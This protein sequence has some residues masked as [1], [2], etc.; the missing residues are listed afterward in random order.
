MKSSYYLAIFRFTT[1]SILSAKFNSI[2]TSEFLSCLKSLIKLQ[3]FVVLF[4]NLRFHNEIIQFY[5]YLSEKW[6]IGYQKALKFQNLN[7][8]VAMNN[9]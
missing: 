8:I 7:S 5:A 9:V 3:I 4:K 1:L 6:A 2:L